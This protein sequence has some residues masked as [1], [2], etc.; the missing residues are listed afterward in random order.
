[1][2]RIPYE[3]REYQRIMLDHILERPRSSLWVP[4]GFGKTVVVLT[5]LDMLDLV[6]PGLTL[7]VAP[8][9]VARS[10]WPAEAAKWAHLRG[11]ELSAVIGTEAERIVA[12]KRKASIYT[13]NYD[14]L[15]WLADYLGER[16]PFR[17]VVADEA[18][19]LKGFRLLQGTK[20]ARVLGRVA[21]SAVKWWVNL[22]GTPSPNGLK[23]LWGQ[24]YFVDAGA[25]LGRTY[26]A[27]KERWFRPSYDGYDIV[28][29]PFAREQIEDRLR[30]T[31][32]SLRIEDWFDV[33]KPIT[34]TVFVDLPSKARALYRDMERRMFMELDG[35]KIE[36]FNAAAKSIKCLQVASG[37]AYIDAHATFWKEIHSEKLSALESIA[38]EAAG[39]SL[40]IVY[41]FKT[42]LARILKAFPKA[43]HIHSK[44]D[45]DDWN[46]GKIPMGVIHPKSGGEGLNLQDGGR[47]IVFFGHW[48]NLAEYQQIIGRIGPVR[49]MQSGHPRS[50]FVHHIVARD[51]VD[52]DVMLRRESKRD[53]QDI[54][55]AAMNRRKGK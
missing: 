20:R 34:N 45:E 35:H 37:A 23:D 6:E 19:R 52:E 1:M 40:L 38:T 26:S 21:H 16:W 5:A 54:L 43:R 29:L 53:V 8:M 31:C 49:Q 12:L 33:T 10:V 13:I 41:Q 2:N 9:R 11:V 7:V 28:P 32:L 36:A 24:M 46:T 39:E 22:T 48:W 42:E 3:P 30:D 27:F 15:P 50:V 18:V 17:K 14:N 55:L 4:M 44:Q 51:T 25:A 47:T